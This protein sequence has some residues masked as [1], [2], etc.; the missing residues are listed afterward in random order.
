MQ[1][2]RK[3]TFELQL[4]G[5]LCAKSRQNYGN[6]PICTSWTPYVLLIMYSF[7]F[8]D[9]MRERMM[10]KRHEKLPE[11]NAQKSRPPILALRLSEKVFITY[12]DKHL[13]K[14]PLM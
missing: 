7:S 8:L 13:P 10:R 1:S 3:P 9:P 4:L 14:T 6:P 11:A 12:C 2:C 5:S